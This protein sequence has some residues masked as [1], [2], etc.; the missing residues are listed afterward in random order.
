[1]WFD[2]QLHLARRSREGNWDLKRD[3]FILKKDENGIEHVSLAY[4]AETKNHKDAKD[5]CKGNY[6]GYIFA[7]P[8]NPNCPVASFKKYVSLCPPNA[9]AFYL[10]P[11]KKDQQQLNQQDVWYSR[12]AMGHNFLG[13]MSRKKC[14]DSDFRPHTWALLFK[15]IFA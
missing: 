8:E 6:R 5:P 14:L 7:E 1:M 13:Q 15:C 9:D 10:H 2:V 11:L 3:S 4:N 12:E